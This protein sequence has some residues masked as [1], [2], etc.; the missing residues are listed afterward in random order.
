MG[1]FLGPGEGV[2]GGLVE[3]L[4]FLEVGELVDDAVVAAFSAALV[5]P[6]AGEGGWAGAE[7]VLGDD[8]CG[9]VGEGDGVG[10]L[11]LGGGEAF[12]GSGGR[13]V[14]SAWLGN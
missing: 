8:F 2:V 10:L 7:E 12:A 6:D 14:V 4:V 13:G 11:F 1:L 9:G 3:I 5:V